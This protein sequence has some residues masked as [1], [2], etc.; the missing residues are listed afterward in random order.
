MLYKTVDMLA[1]EMQ[2]KC[3]SFLALCAVDPVIRAFGYTV[4]LLETLRELT[5]QLAYFCSGRMQ[6]PE[7]VQA[8]FAAV[9]LWAI[10][11]AEAQ[12]ER[13]WTLA[14][15]HFTGRAFDAA[16]SR[17][18]KNPDWQAP[19]EVWEAMH[20]IARSLG[21]RCGADFKA[22]AKPDAPHYELME[23]CYGTL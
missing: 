18:G 8:I 19:P 1:P 15:R 7:D 12:K 17:D 23:G 14:S 21:L 4:I 20:K 9:G 3:L 16:P 10:T 5:T 2:S 6:R 11:T 13:T 22:P